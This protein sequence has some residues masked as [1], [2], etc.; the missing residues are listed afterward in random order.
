MRRVTKP[1]YVSD[2]GRQLLAVRDGKVFVEYFA[3]DLT[4]CELEELAVACQAAAE[5]LRA[6][7]AANA[8]DG[9]E[10]VR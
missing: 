3:A 7:Q 5:E 4:A 2:E 1:Y 6:I 8:N 9:C 10:V